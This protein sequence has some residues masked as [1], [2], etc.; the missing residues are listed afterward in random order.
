M[1]KKD[2]KGKAG[3]KKEQDRGAKAGKPPKADKKAKADKKHKPRAGK[4]VAA[5]PRGLGTVTPALVFKDSAAAIAF[6]QQAFGAKE[7]SRM[8]SPDGKSVWHAELKIGD[9]VL[10]LNDESPMSHEVAPHEGH[11]AT[12]GLQLYVK[13]CDA[14]IARAVQAGATLKM[15]PADM[16]WGDRMGMVVDPFGLGWN[17]G[18]RIRD[19]SAREME[20][21]GEEFARSFAAQQAASSEPAPASDAPPESSEPPASL[22]GGAPPAEPVAVEE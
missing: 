13:D 16:F 6:Y 2:K 18:T 10:Y 17:I 4:K 5:V 15:A 19:L 22:E 14:W 9:S 21:A 8:M 7:R 12:S 11:R 3:G 1:A 20:R